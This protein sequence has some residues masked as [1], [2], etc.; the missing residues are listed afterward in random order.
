MRKRVG[1]I[2]VF[3][4]ALCILSSLGFVL[5][6]RWEDENA[7][8]ISQSLLKDV[9]SIIDTKTTE[10]GGSEPLPSPPGKGPVDIEQIPDDAENEPDGSEPLPSLPGTVPEGAEQPPIDTESFLYLP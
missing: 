8:K 7:G 1:I 6:N 2:C 4:G 9:Q 5:Y 3:L 10:L